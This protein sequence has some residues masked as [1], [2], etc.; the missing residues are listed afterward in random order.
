MTTFDGL[1]RF[2]GVKFSVFNKAALKDLPSNRFVAVFA[3]ADGTLWAASDTNGL[4]RY[5]DGKVEATTEVEGLPLKRLFQIQQDVD[6]SLLI[7]TLEGF[8]RWK[9]NKF[10]LE[11]K[12]DVRDFRVYISPSG[13]R[14]ELDA[15]GLRR[16]NQAG[17]KEE[18]SAPF[19]LK[20]IAEDPT[21][22]YISTVP[23]FED[24]SGALWLA[25]GGNLYR[26]KNGEVAIF[27]AKAGMPDSIVSDIAEDSEGKIW[28]GTDKNGLC[29]LNE[30]K[31]NC[32]DKSKGLSSNFVRDIFLDR[33]GTLWITTDDGGINRITKKAVTALSVADG[34]L[35][36]NIYPI[37]RDRSDSLWIGSWKGLSQISN[38]VTKNYSLNNPLV[39][40]FAQAIHE[41]SQSR[42]WVGAVGGVQYF[43]DGKLH[44]F[45]SQTGFSVGSA[46]YSDIHEGRDGTIWFATNQGLLKL[47]NDSVTRVTT[48]DG[49]PTNDVRLIFEKQDGSFLLGTYNGLTVMTAGGEIRQTFTERDGLAGNFIRAI[50]ED[51]DGT[52]WIGTYDS[53]LSRLKDGK[54][55]TYNTSNGMFSNGVFAILEDGRGNFWMSSNQGIYRV[56]K[57]ELNDFADGKLSKVTST[58]YGK[59]DG[60]LN[61]ECNGG[62]QP[63][64]LKNKDG[65]L[66]FPT[67]DGVAII[68]PEAVPFNPNPP[69]VVIESAALGGNSVDIKDALAVQP[70]RGNLEIRYTGLSF[71][72]SE[73]TRFRYKLEGLDEAWT[74]AG[75]RREAFYP[76]LPPGTYT[77]RVIAANSDNVWNEQGATLQ[78]TVFPPFYQ[79]WWFVIISVFTIA[80]IAYFWNQRRIDRLTRERAAQQNFAWQ[81]IAS[82]EAERKRIAGEL[83]DSLGQR[84][85]IIKNLALSFLNLK[86]EQQIEQISNEAS[87]A[88]NEVKSISYNLRPYQLD[89]I[90]LTKA[91]EAIVRSAESASEIEF[92]AE[93]DDIDGYFPKDQEINFYRIVQESVN[94]ILKHSN[95]ERA[96]VLIK[97]EERSLSVVIE[98]NGIGYSA[99]T[100]SG[101]FG[102][103]GIR[104]RVDLLNGTLEIKTAPGQGVIIKIFIQE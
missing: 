86:S 3:E 92:S 10:S 25:A 28:F 13:W 36:R 101:G 9:E 55:S 31:V 56:S 40:E 49:L 81:M 70:N 45:T 84:L 24:R 7:T 43:K 11:K 60:M 22:N 6:G 59:S 37:F 96:S 52:L 16:I 50:Y 2:D 30:N 64:A 23:M 67:Q 33:E 48:E 97:S 72:K 87:Q 21:L 80:A 18:F 51:P 69:P 100:K 75:T 88:I 104:E 90:G 93:I 53:G 44:D 32:Y 77:F 65:K 26:L 98:D 99:A 20:T 1:V 29:H 19:D 35:D 34:L 39:Y 12:Q 74:E 63:S 85:V 5:K 62:R 91:I 68:D 76:Y 46:D 73:Q 78:I 15:N 17:V 71:I 58:A 83:H 89:R 66:W 82:Q 47:K 42:L 27:E 61:P 14:W 41:D 103:I 54:F 8:V 94:N 38:G 57:Q 95:A 4:I 79:T 102:L